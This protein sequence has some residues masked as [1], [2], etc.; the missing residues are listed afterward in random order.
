MVLYSSFRSP[1]P[2]PHNVLEQ[3]LTPGLTVKT[4][5]GSLSLSL[6]LLLIEHCSP[7]LFFLSSASFVW[8]ARTA[9]GADHTHARKDKMREGERRENSSS[10]L[11]A[12]RKET[13][14]HESEP[15]I[16]K[17][18]LAAVPGVSH[19]SV[20]ATVYKKI[21][22]IISQEEENLGKNFEL[23]LVLLLL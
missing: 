23:R 11:I 19:L 3:I 6:S 2:V 5:S 22:K 10:M 4:W 8:R 9:F 12:L 14:G 16:G 1:L 15:P 20:Q 17:Q 13:V 18:C 7:E 21:D